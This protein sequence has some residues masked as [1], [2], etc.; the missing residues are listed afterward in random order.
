MLL[1]DE[2]G[3]DSALFGVGHVQGHG[4]GSLEVLG[5]AHR[6]LD[7][8]VR[9]NDRVATACDLSD[10]SIAN[11]RPRVIRARNSLRIFKHNLAVLLGYD[12]P[13]EVWEDIPLQLSGRLTAE[14]YE[15]AMPVALGQALEKR[16]ELGVL[17]TA[18]GIAVGRRAAS[19]RP[20]ALTRRRRSLRDGGT[21]LERWGRV[22]AGFGDPNVNA[23]SVACT[24]TTSS[25]VMLRG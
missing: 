13:H 4:F 24:L 1:G 7:Y 10:N 11:A 6:W 17:R 14:P 21:P 9:D 23:V 22:G 20:S 12:V 15:I 2:F 16:P 3:D 19:D 18:S 8:K 25:R 5:D